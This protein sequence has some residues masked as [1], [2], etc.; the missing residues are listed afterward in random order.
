MTRIMLAV[1]LAFLAAPA[2]AACYQ[3]PVGRVIDGDTFEV[4]IPGF[5]PEL[6]PRIRLQNADTPELRGRCEAE[7]A[8]A[9]QA[10]EA[11]EALL[12]SG[13]VEICPLGWGKYGGTIR[14]MVWV[15]QV[16]LGEELARRGLARPYGGERR[17]PWCP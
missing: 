17:Q 13:P 8:L 14:A 7:R 15:G 6:Q 11:T 3:W 12:A 5:P 4:A 10:K 1:L 2:S 16:D 9:L